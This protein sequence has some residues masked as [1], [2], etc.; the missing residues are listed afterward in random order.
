M[1][2][3]EN[4]SL[5]GRENSSFPFKFRETP[6]LTYLASVS[7]VVSEENWVKLK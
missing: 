3:F 4:D 7:Q 6:A 5:Y 2:Q 1:T